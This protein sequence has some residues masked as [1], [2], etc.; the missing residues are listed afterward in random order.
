[1]FLS[2]LFFAGCATQQID[3]SEIGAD[4][5]AAVSLNSFSKLITNR[6]FRMMGF[7]SRDEV[8]RATL[9]KSIREYVIELSSIKG[10]KENMNPEKLLVRTR[11]LVYPVLI[12]SSI[13]TSLTIA[14]RNNR[15]ESQ[16]FGYSNLTKIIAALMNAKSKEPGFSRNVFFI[17]R[18]PA[19]NLAFLGYRFKGTLTLIP[20]FDSPAFDLKTG[21]P[22]PAS[23]VVKVLKTAS[24][25]YK[26]L[27]R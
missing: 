19:F 8:R 18:V 2:I 1:M 20:L 5:A 6:N 24:E 12:D 26:D 23:I 4:K 25:E 15:W 9:D 13:R 22:V 17:V 3:I 27:P 10:F 21:I 16:S 11:T 14:Y 7:E